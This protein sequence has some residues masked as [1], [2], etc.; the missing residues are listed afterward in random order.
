MV[1]PSAFDVRLVEAWL[2][3]PSVRHLVFERTDGAP[4]D[5]EPGQWVNLLM[6][7]ASGE[8]IKRSYSIASAPGSSR[9]ELCVTQV[10][11]GPGSGFLHA[12]EVGA[13]VRAVGPQGLF[14]RAATDKAA[15]LFVATGTGVAPFRSIMQAAVSRGIDAPLWLLFGTRFEDDILYRKEIEGMVE[16]SPMMRYEVTLSRASDGWAGR[17]GYVQGHVAELL[18]ALKA[19]SNEEPHVWICGLDKMVSSVKE[20]CRKELGVDRKRVHTERYD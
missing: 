3:A 11:G 10:V 12:M 15:A 13:E 19:R 14:T 17:R 5:F 18:S 6:P 16:R 4:V 20:L 9:F 7:T 1:T 2:I 8:L